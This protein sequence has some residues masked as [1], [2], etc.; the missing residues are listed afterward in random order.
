MLASMIRIVVF[1]ISV[2]IRGLR[3]ACRSRADL[4]V[5]NL[6]LR[7][8][9][10]AL[11]QARPKPFLHDVDR[12]FWI[13]L[14]AAWTKWKDRLVIV[15]PE[16]VI[17]WHRR[18]FRRH[19]TKISRQ[20]HGPGRPPLKAEVRKLIR[21]MALENAWGAPRIHGELAKLGFVIS[22]ASVSRYMPRLP[23]A[24]GA[25]ERWLTF[26]RNHMDSTAAMDFFTIPTVQLRQ[27]YCFFVIH[28]GRRRIL[29]FA[30]TFNPTSQ[31]VIQ[32][33]R[34]AFP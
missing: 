15:K 34:E 14:L 28:H 1:L 25:R 11:K 7:Q 17:D 19:W 6:T 12:A 4:V 32:Q 5:E 13:A 24:P 29:H 9:V 23:P 2:V 10:T 20:N 33:L 31:W 22:E 30:A 16:T 27:L 21:K 26:L 18:R 3:A 8:Q